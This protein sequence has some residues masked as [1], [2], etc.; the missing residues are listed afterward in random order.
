MIWNTSSVHAQ[1]PKQIRCGIRRGSRSRGEHR[2][3]N[4]GWPCCAVS[5]IDALGLPI[6][7]NV[8]NGG[9]NVSPDWVGILQPHFHHAIQLLAYDYQ[10]AFVYRDAW[11]SK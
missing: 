6:E 9:F 10:V 2:N 5:V 4:A 8:N 7:N 3:S 1:A 11:L